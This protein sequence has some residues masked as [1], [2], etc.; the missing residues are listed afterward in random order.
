[1]LLSH[2]FALRGDQRYPRI[3]ADSGNPY[4]VWEDDRSFV[5]DTVTSDKNVFMQKFD[6]STGSPQWPAATTGVGYTSPY[7]VMDIRTDTSEKSVPL[8][9]YWRMSMLVFSLVPR[10]QGLPGWA[11]YTCIPVSRVNR[12]CSLISLPWS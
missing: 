8:G 9:K 3:A 5:G 6:G 4:V 10:S 1:M 11:K 7:A 12:V 2:D